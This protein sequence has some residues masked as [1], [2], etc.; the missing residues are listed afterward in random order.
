MR[1][2]YSCTVEHYAAHVAL[3]KAWTAAVGREGYNK[4]IW[5]DAEQ[6]LHEHCRGGCLVNPPPLNGPR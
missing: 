5:C 1:L 4:Q 6:S 2:T 3:H